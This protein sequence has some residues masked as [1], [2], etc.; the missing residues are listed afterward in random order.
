MPIC[1]YLYF[2][3]Q[4]CS[5]SIDPSRRFQSIV[6]FL[7][8]LLFSPGVDNAP[9]EEGTRLLRLPVAARAVQQKTKS[10]RPAARAPPEG[11]ATWNRFGIVA[12]PFQALKRVCCSWVKEVLHCPSEQRRLAWYCCYGCCGRRRGFCCC[13]GFLPTFCSRRGARQG[14]LLPWRGC[15]CGGPGMLGVRP[16]CLQVGCPVSFQLVHG[17]GPQAGSFLF[18]SRLSVCVCLCP[19]ASFPPPVDPCSLV[20]ACLSFPSSPFL[21][22]PPVPWL[23]PSCLP[24]TAL[25]LHRDTSATRLVSSAQIAC[26]CRTTQ[27]TPVFP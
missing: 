3:F 8:F 2:P 17:A 20:R 13:C 19:A 12:T 10:A 4:L 24:C 22:C 6:L 23:S 1:V 15:S 25:Q 5:R 7:F 11:P 26:F 16:V 9:E 21:L 18:F 27:L 14:A